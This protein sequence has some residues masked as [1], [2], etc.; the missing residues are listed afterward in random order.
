[1]KI[2]YRAPICGVLPAVLRRLFWGRGYYLFSIKEAAKAF[3]ES[4]ADARK[5][6]KCLYSE[7]WINAE[8][9]LSDRE[10]HVS[11]VWMP[12]E[13][14]LRLA[15]M[16][17]VK[18]FSVSEGREIVK[19]VIEVTQQTNSEPCNSQRI[20]KIILFGSILTGKDTD[21]AGDVDLDVTIRVRKDIPSE[22]LHR[23]AELE[24]EG[25]AYHPNLYHWGGI[26]LDRRIK[27]VS[28]R[29]SLLAGTIDLEW[30]QRV[31]YQFDNAAGKE[32]PNC[33]VDTIGGEFIGLFE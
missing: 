19:R 4:E 11:R 28:H 3:G 14:G 2:D 25:R 1:M 23:L 24:N 5:R 26:L 13:N 8:G 12:T 17:M 10:D 32:I 16:P 18:R 6:L 20:T 33:L 22:E 31:V 9:V 7:G 29:I 27:K 30:P 15:A 21:D